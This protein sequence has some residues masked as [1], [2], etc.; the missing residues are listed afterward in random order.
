[1]WVLKVYLA[2]SRYCVSNWCKAPRMTRASPAV[3]HYRMMELMD[4]T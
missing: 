4:V 2:C 3:A 1:M